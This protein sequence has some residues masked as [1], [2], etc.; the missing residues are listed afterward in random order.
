MS[1]PQCRGIEKLFDRSTAAADLKRYRQRGPAK[2][3]RLLLD[4]LMAQDVTGLTLLDIGG[5]IGAIQ[6]HLI[7]AGVG[8]VVNVD[9]SSAYLEAAKQ[10]AARLGHAAQVNYH[11]GDFVTLAPDLSAADIVT[12]DRVI[13]CY[14]DMPAL[15]S[16]SSAKARRFYALVFPRDA[17]IMRLAAVML[18]IF[19][20]LQRSSMRFFIHPTAKVNALVEQ[21]GFKR[22]FHHKT[23]LWQV[24]CRH[25]FWR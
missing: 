5:G 13:C 16:A 1:C 17:W 11:H 23:L 25:L 2:E 8:A 10:E 12:L 21:A 19:I 9:A 22:R 4:R 24:R 18:N 7:S 15:V 6:H 14:H 20:R 3:T